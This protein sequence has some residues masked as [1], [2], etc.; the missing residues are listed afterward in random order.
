M[1]LRPGKDP[2]PREP[3]TKQ[4]NDPDV[5]CI[6]PPRWRLGRCGLSF[7]LRYG[8]MYW[9]IV[10]IIAPYCTMLLAIKLTN[11]AATCFFRPRAAACLLA[12]ASCTV[13]VT[14][15]RLLSVH[16]VP[17]GSY[18][19]INNRTYLLCTTRR[20][21]RCSRCSGRGRGRGRRTTSFTV[22]SRF[23][24]KPFIHWKDH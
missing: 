15:T 11:T 12:I 6:L 10:P 19:Q 22:G 3:C 13:T 4:Y 20:R 16:A 7:S 5:I 17:L 8:C 18:I 24:K 1:G 21:C 14:F 9:E 2:G 23:Q